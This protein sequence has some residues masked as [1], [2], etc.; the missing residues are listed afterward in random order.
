MPFF[1][2]VADLPQGAALLAAGAASVWVLAA[3]DSRVQA[4]AMV[5]ALILAALGLVAV[6]GRAIAD[7]AAERPAAAAAALAVGLAAVA[8]CAVLVR[9][10]PFML[11]LLALGA[12]AFRIPVP[13]GDERV[14]LL[15]PLYGVIA[16]GVLAQLLPRGRDRPQPGVP[17]DRRRV[18]LEQALAVVVGCYALQGLYST[19]PEQAIKTLC[20]FLAPFAVLYRLVAATP[21]TPRLAP[22]AFGVVAVLAVIFAAIGLVE[23]STGHLIVSNPKVVDSNELKPYFRVNSLFFDPNIYGRFLALAMTAVATALL[24]S[25]HRGRT[26]A[27]GSVLAL[28]WA[29]LVVS[30]SQSSFAA[31]LVGLLALAALRWRLAPVAALTAAAVLAGVALV[32]LAPGAVGLEESSFKGVDR[33]TSGRL[34]LVR[35][36]LEMARDRPLAGF[37]SGS[38]AERYRARER[39]FSPRVAAV[40]HTTPVTVAAEQGILGLAGYGALLWAALGLVFAGARAPRDGGSPLQDAVRAALAAAFLALVAHTMAYAAFLEDPLTWVLL[41][42]AAA[43]RAATLPEDRRRRAERRASARPA[44]RVPVG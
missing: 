21:W 12:L 30:L 27:L 43:V 11:V 24:W 18:R 39:V 7:T 9:R 20:F 42:L 13:V 37:G 16:A 34:G 25:R 17:E 2:A 22:P 26:A 19:D 14:N 29:G 6:S 44:P 31:L 28:L 35:G 40:S 5:A 38:F 36:G 10:R 41:A 32:A 3:R 4:W 1:L 8:A 15:I 33:A 23:Y